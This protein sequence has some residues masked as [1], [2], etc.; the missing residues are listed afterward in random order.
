[1]NTTEQ[2]LVADISYEWE[3]FRFDGLHL[4]FTQHCGTRLESSRCSH[5]GPSV[6]KWQGRA[7][8]GINAKKTGVLIGETD[9]LRQR[10]KQYVSGTQE[11]G[12]RLWR[13]NFLRP[14]DASLWVL[15]LHG[16]TLT[17][18]GQAVTV[19]LGEVL[20][21]SNRRLVVEQLLVMQA[22]HEAQ[23]SVWVVNARQ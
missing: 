2:H 21:S 16:L 22:L 12:N 19:P 15:R 20:A 17:A 8:T 6:Y 5:W 11:R 4:T 13:E 18:G 3:P 9:N 7:S 10:I 14:C 23:D 1:V